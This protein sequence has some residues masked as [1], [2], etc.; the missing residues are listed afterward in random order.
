MIWVSGP[1]K[2]CAFFS[3]GWLAFTGTTMEQA[4]GNG[5]AGKIHQDDR[6]NCRVNYFSAFDGRRRFQTECRLLRADGEYRW[7]LTTGAPRFESSG[8]FGGYVGTCTDITEIKRSQEEALARQKL[9]GLGVLAGGIA[10]DFNNLLGSILTT[11]ELVRSELPEDSPAHDGL[12]SIKI[13]ADRAGG[14]CTPDD[15]I[16]GTRKG[17]IRTT[18]SFRIG[19]RNA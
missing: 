11:S 18:Q 6:E 19:P 13:V 8:V 12:D 14:Y 7:V 9:E 1:D 16:C 2:L 10:H 4:L 5:W 15:G 17:G 3:Q